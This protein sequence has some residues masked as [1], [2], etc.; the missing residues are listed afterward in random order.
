MDT[1][2]DGKIDQAE[3]DAMKAKREGH[4]MDDKHDMD[5]EAKPK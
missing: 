4:K 1:N 5:K 2:K 3:R